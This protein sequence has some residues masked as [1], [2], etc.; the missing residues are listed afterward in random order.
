[1]ITHHSPV[2]A[3][4]MQFRQIFDS[5]EITFIKGDTGA[6]DEVDQFLPKAQLAVMAFLLGNVFANCGESCRAHGEC[7]IPI[8]P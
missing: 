4:I 6:L 3:G 8:L 7:H 5:I 1:M 2:P